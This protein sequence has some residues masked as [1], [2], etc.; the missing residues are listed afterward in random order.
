MGVFWHNTAETWI[1]VVSNS[2]NN[3][4]SSIVN[5]VSG[6]TKEPQVDVHFMSESGIIDV[7]FMM[8][9]RPYDVFRQYSA[10]TGTAPLPPVSYQRQENLYKNEKSLI[11][12]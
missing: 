11:S 7:F 12:C 1:D 2:D 3:V 5:F 6:G 8:G 4:V 9:P 10:L